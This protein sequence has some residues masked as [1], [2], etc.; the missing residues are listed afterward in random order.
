MSKRKVFNRSNRKKD[1]SIEVETTT[2]YIRT[3]EEK[4][5]ISKKKEELEVPIK[6][7][8][9][10]LYSKNF[11]QKKPTTLPSG[12]KQPLKRLS[13]ESLGTIEH[14]VDD[15]KYK[16]TELS[17][18][19]IQTSDDIDQIVDHVLSKNKVW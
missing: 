19:K 17:R 1:T 10:M 9:E 15:M 18:N 8:N 4:P 14:V 2:Q 6:E 12:I 16:N 7:Y 3:S 11:I 5:K 13:W